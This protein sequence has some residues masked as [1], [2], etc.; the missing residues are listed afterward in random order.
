MSNFPGPRR[1]IDTQIEIATSPERVWSVLTD[2]AAYPSWNPFIRK[3]TGRLEPRQRLTVCL[4]GD[5]AGGGMVFHPEVVTVMP[6]QRLQW[7]G[8][9]WGL[10]GLLTGTHDFE[11]TQTGHGT[12][13]RQ[14]EAFAGIL[15]WF[16]DV[17]TVRAEF[18]KMNQALKSRAEAA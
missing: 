18:I 16:Y 12:L 14:S 7:I 11:I 2:M 4:G 5:K 8:R 10:P 9:L 17:E 15:L 3:L 13:F 1:H 6:G